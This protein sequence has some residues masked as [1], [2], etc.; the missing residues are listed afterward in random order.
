MLDIRDD[1]NPLIVTLGNEHL[2]KSRTHGLFMMAAIFNMASQ[3]NY[4]VSMNASII[5]NAIATANVYDKATGIPT[6]RPVN[7]NGNWNAGAAVQ[8]T[9]PIDR[10]KRITL[11]EAFSANYSNS[12]DLTTV[13]AVSYTHLMDTV[14]HS[15]G[16]VTALNPYI[17]YKNST[18]VAKEALETGKSLHE[19]VLEKKLL[20]EEQV[21]EILDPKAMLTAHN[22]I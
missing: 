19:I 9:T 21:D 7:I 12:V 10:R 18:K 11:E 13:K 3:R 22:K 2:K 6:T 15:I 1:A 4:S 8:T 16:I 14:K 5:Q 20:T 17:G